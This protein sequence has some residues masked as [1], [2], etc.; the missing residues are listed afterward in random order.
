MEEIGI[1]TREHR[2]MDSVLT[3]MREEG[4]LDEEALRRVS[5]LVAEGKALEDAAAA[6]GVSEERLLRLLA[7]LFDI[8]YVELEARGVSREFL[9]RFPAR[10][11]VEH[12]I[13]PLEERDG[14]VTVASSRIGDGAGLDELALAS[15]LDI[16]RV[17]APSS[18]IDRC[19]KRLLGVG[20]DTLQSMVSDAGDDVQVIDAGDEEDLDLND[21]AE[22]ASIIKLVNQILTEAIELRAT[23][24]HVEPFEDQ[25]RVRYR[26]DGILQ[27]ANVP[28]E[29]RRFQAA[30]VSRLKILSRLDIAEKRLP[31]DGRIR[32]KISGREIDVR[33]SIIPMLHGEAVVLRILDRKDALLGV[34]HL[35]LGERDRRTF[36]RVLE[37]PHGIVLVT[38]PTGSGKTT[39]LYAA[40]TKINDIE[41]KIVTIEDPV[42]YQLRGINQIQVSTRT[43]LTFAVGL[44]AILRHDPDV[45]LIGEIRDHETAEIAVQA[46]L[47]GHLVFSTLHTNDAPSAAA[48]LVDMGVEPYLVASTLEMVIAQRLVRLI[49]P[50]CK[51]ELPRAEAL[52]ETAQIGMPPGQALFRGRGCRNC[53]GTGYRGRTG[54]FELLPIDEEVRGLILRRAPAGEVRAM[55]VGRGMR[56]LRE[57]GYRLVV[58]GRTT[59]EEVLRT[60]KDIG[61]RAG[62][63]GGPGERP[64]D[65]FP[66]P[67]G[68]VLS[69]P[70]KAG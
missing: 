20:A 34:E 51:E 4:L 5:A 35:G 8:P 22:N 13:L 49:C 48:R 36:D 45:V 16:A 40:V 58:E 52:L 70:R 29:V 9:A 11:L 14:V 30:L 26:I 68:V 42:E 44:R 54:I 47:T 59:L 57:D 25:L 39:T 55:A 62:A 32:L 27:E 67:G 28:A 50:A 1:G 56:T 37:L 63:G 18:E 53:Q 64:A 2:A 19:L 17:L 38:G 23:D 33:V 66:V 3:R 46:S 21:D 60:T 61:V 31:Q 41:R 43:G 7:S 6:A 15:G 12:R 69:A 24:V 10:I 65:T